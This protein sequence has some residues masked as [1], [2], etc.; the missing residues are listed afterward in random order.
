[1]LAVLTGFSTILVAV[2]VGH[3]LGGLK[4][5]P[6]EAVNTVAA[7]AFYV[8]TPAKMFQVASRADPSA[9]FSSYLLAFL[10]ASLLT[11][12]VSVVVGWRLST[13][14]KVM[15]AMGAA[16]TNTANLGLPIAHHVLGDAAWVAP[17]FLVQVMFL[18]PLALL[19]MDAVRAR[20]DSRRLGVG[21]LA[22]LVLSNPVTLGTMLGFLVGWSRVQL[23]TF[24]SAPID[25]LAEMSIPL[26]LIAFGLGLRASGLPRR[27]TSRAGVMVAAKC[28]LMPAAAWTIATLA[29]MGPEQVRAATVLSALPTAQVVLVH[30]IRYD[31]EVPLIQQ[32][33]VAT[34]VLSMPVIA[35][36]ALLT[37]CG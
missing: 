18:Q 12:A 17:L 31:V 36:G 1:M 28:L 21:A 19:L 15:T 24:I 9:L 23:P 14:R 7:L 6:K 4:A 33:S 2:A 30:A 32:V 29:G 8:A 34:T 37:P 5:F 10:G 3:A 16:Y 27:L 22:R 26:M 25:L 13:E 20:G 11:V 35:V